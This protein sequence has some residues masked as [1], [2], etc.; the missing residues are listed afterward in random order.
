[1]AQVCPICN[2]QLEE[3]AA[4]CKFCGFRIP[5]STQSFQPVKVQTEE[6]IPQR[7]MSQKCDLRVIRGPQ[8]GMQISLNEG[9]MKLGRDP[10]CDIFLNDMTV[11]RSHATIEVTGSGCVIRDSNSFNGVWVNDR[12]VNTCLLKIGDVIQIGA[13][14]LVYRER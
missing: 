3:G 12:N 5:G 1:M 14:C 11:S 13:F 9:I 10:K 2:N 6:P 7:P 4:A 8:T